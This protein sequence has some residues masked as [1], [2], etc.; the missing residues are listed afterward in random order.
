MIDT[1]DAAISADVFAQDW[2]ALP[3]GLPP[4]DAVRAADF[5][6]AFAAAIE[7]HAAE[8]ERIASD[9]AAPDFANVIGALE[10]SGRRLGRL[11]SAFWTLAGTCSDE[12]IRAVEREIAPKLARHSAS[13]WMDSRLAGRAAK[14]DEGG[15]DEE[16][17]RVLK[18]YRDGFLRSG[19]MLSGAPRARMAEIAAELAEL[20]AAFGQN[21]LADE[22]AWGLEITD[23]AE[24]EG[25]PGFLRQAAARAAKDRGKAGWVITL[26]RSL[27][28]PFLTFSARRDL[29]EKAWR[30]WTARGTGAP[31][32]TEA[33]DNRPLIARI[34]KLRSEKAR[35]LGFRT[36]ADFKLKP[37][38]AG[39]PENV[40]DLLD[41]VRGPALARAAEEEA[42]LRALAAELDGLD[43]FQP[44][45]WRY[46]AEIL[47]KRRHDLDE[48]EIKPYLP[49]GR[50]REA[51]FDTATRLFGLSFEAVEGA[52]MHHPSAEAFAVRRGD[53]AVG[54][55]IMD[56]FARSSK[57]SGAW[58]SALT[59]QEALG[60]EDIR[61]VVINVMN[62]AEAPEGEETLLT[63]DDARTLFHEFGHA[64]HGLMSDV[65]HPFVSGTSVARDF[66]EL[67]SQIFERWLLTPQILSAHA[68]HVETGEPI[69]AE[70]AERVRGAEN[71][72]QGF[73]T[74]EYLASAYVDLEAHLLEAGALE[75]FDAQVFE[76]EVLDRIG[77]PA[78][79]RSRHAAPHFL[80]VF[81][82]DGYSA[83][84]YSYLW[85]EVMDADAFRA[86]EEAG[87]VFDADVAGRFAG[88]VLTAGGRQD[89]AEAYRAFR[90]RDPE[91]K[92]LLE[93][94]GLV[95]A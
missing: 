56:P 55:F 28:D 73:A 37:Q 31:V 63:L 47:R 72:G 20:G 49:L 1:D 58:M 25:C 68:R 3:F 15:L 40:R 23:E 82:G 33:T 2:T 65:K 91:P 11:A 8:V 38:M 80:H 61:P 9:A 60:N 21:V 29:R 81:S 12:D 77:M 89:P 75:G 69:P 57:R 32:F 54:T 18:L 67:P 14:I 26:S 4:W 35:L 43:D 16:E 71:F 30:A 90:G 70:L 53:K 66:V 42:E 79:I 52:A 44:W 19:A 88:A 94:R 83:G 50:I 6:A 48:A 84:Y 34:L 41:R 45:D 85:A 13:V 5:R 59:S 92:A 62:F 93:A 78:A 74:C 64:L 7:D 86:F 27:V 51:A 39:S 87:D 10:R 76:A 36:F 95:P 17:A 46:Y 24:L 22:A